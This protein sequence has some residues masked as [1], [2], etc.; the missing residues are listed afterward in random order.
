[1]SERIKN[2]K[3]RIALLR[4]MI[5]EATAR[6]ESIKKV[7]ARFCCDTG[8]TEFTARKYLRLLKDAELIPET[9]DA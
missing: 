2:R 9:I 8:V 7:L 6:G 5:N 4:K 1:M 3:N